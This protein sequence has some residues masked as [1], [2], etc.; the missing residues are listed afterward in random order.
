M[1]I[2]MSK[3]TIESLTP[4]E[5]K[6]ALSLLDREDRKKIARD[7]LYKEIRSKNAAWYASKAKK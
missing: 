4:A 5:A 2:T 7:K 6:L 1:M 3:R